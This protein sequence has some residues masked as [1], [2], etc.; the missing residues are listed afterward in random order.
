MTETATHDGTGGKKPVLLL[1]LDGWGLASADSGGAANS[2]IELADTPVWD[3]LW[4][5]GQFPTT[6]LIP[7]GALVGLTPGQMGN[8]EVGHLNLGAGR[9][10]YQ[11]LVAITRMIQRSDFQKHKALNAFLNTCWENDAALHFVGLFSDGGVHS[12]VDHLYGLIEYAKSRGAR[13]IWIHALLD[14]RDTPPRKAEEYFRTA[15][16][17]LPE[18]V[19]FATLGGRYYGMDRDKRWDRVQRAWEVI[20]HGVKAEGLRPKAQGQVEETQETSAP[21]DLGLRPLAFPD[22][23][24]ALAAA[25][26]RGEGDEFVTPCVLGD[27]PG[28]ADG[29]HVFFFNFRADRMRQLV[30]CFTAGTGPALSATA[31]GSGAEDGRGRPR[32]G[33]DAAQTDDAD[34]AGPVPTAE[35]GFDRGRVPQCVL[36]SATQYRDDFTFSVLLDSHVVKETLVEVLAGLGLSTFKCAETEKYAHVTYFFN[37]GRE[38]PWPGEERVLVPSPHV[39]TYDLQ[40]EMSLPAVT[41]KLV[42]ALTA[43]RHALYVVNFAN[44]DMVGH[45]GVKPAEI[46][47]AQ[48]VDAALQRVLDAAGWGE[49]VACLITADHGNCDQLTWADGSPHT[50]HS[51]NDVPL[52]L[53]DGSAPRTEQLRQPGPHRDAHGEER[54]NLALCDIAPT[55][56]ALLGVDEPESWNGVSLVT[57]VSGVR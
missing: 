4:K 35:I 16:D 33:N 39:A 56:L 14:G 19:A 40:P 2:A 47:A 1:I 9:I 17:W 50:Q 55:V 18:G 38:E 5:S 51:M 32:P 3:K 10:V 7:H 22:W 23:Q 30:S 21:S 8:S 36:M 31:S 15:Q 34:G 12:H 20:A 54:A 53:V 25:R 6:R 49:R 57:E 26:E 13:R 29:D 48:A 11:D 42:E 28:I 45:T 46:K 37:G 24:S 27:Y 41:D 43:R 52:V 44:G